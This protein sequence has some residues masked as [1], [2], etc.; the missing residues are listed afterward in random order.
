MKENKLLVEVLIGGFMG[1]LAG[2]IIGLMMGI[3]I[4]AIGHFVIVVAQEESF[5]LSATAMSLSG[6]GWGALIGA[7][8]G[9]LAGE[10][11]Q[12]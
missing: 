9:C 5:A 6:M 8:F 2:V 3:L 1:A 7:I 11:Q 12:K 10:K 4:W